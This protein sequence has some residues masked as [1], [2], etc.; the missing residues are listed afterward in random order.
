MAT[1]KALY[2]YSYDYEG[3]RITFR[4][5]EEFQL[6]SKA[7]TDWW[8]VRRWKDGAAQDIYV[9]AVYVKEEVKV[10]KDTNPT[11]EN[12]AELRR[13]VRKAKE[14]AAKEEKLENGLDVRND[15]APPVGP[16]RKSDPS[17]DAGRTQPTPSK[18][19]HSPKPSP[20]HKPKIRQLS[21]PKGHESG[22]SVE[23]E[24][25]ID[26]ASK[27]TP[28]IQYA[29]P[30][31]PPLASSPLVRKG[32]KEGNPGPVAGVPVLK[33][34]K[35]G[36]RPGYALPVLAKPRSRSVNTE[37]VPP[38][39]H[40]P[41]GGS[42]APPTELTPNQPTS[43]TGSLPG[44]AS[45]LG[46]VPP[47]VLPR[48]K[49]SERPKSMIVTSTSPTG[50]EPHYETVGESLKA[51][52]GAKEPSAR[53]GESVGGKIPTKPRPTSGNLGM[54]KTPSP[55]QVGADGPTKVS[56]MDVCV[57]VGLGGWVGCV[58]GAWLEGD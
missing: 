14:K 47:P 5:G 12:V 51:V 23:G 4:N 42:P 8:H 32:S 20:K 37:A 11:Y 53:S 56:R 3:S 43:P 27:T 55:K 9:P 40:S 26:G 30:S 48:V 22:G 6:L 24:K 57:Y 49:H 21:A 46:K 28:E 41:R 39:S 33:G 34:I 50:L 58:G 25:K 29:E 38:P 2:D 16:K 10:E 52:L 45:R 17:Q 36:W 54:R 19:T 31:S 44:V 18:E 7:N 13:R 1:V 15:V 35:D